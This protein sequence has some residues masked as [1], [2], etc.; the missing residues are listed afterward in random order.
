MNLATI[1]AFVIL[2]WQAEEPSGWLLV[3][4]DDI[5][6]TA[7]VVLAQ[8]ALLGLAA[9]LAARRTVRLLVS[10]S[11][12]PRV[13][14]HFYHRT[15]LGLRV[16]LVI[17]F[18]LTMVLTRWPDWFA[19]GPPALRVVGDLIALT[20]FFIGAIVLGLGYKFFQVWLEGDGTPEAPAEAQSGA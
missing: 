7:L 17:G 13:A 1:V 8:P 12:T 2:F 4:D 9:A 20:P 16:S 3:P 5:F 14:Q 11:D 19:F 6:W 18:A 10:H 15:S